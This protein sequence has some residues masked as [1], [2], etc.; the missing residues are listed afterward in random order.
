MFL[1]IPDFFLHFLNLDALELLLPGQI[2]ELHGLP[3]HPSNFPPQE[4]SLLL[5]L[6]PI[7]LERKDMPGLILILRGQHPCGMLQLAQGVVMLVCEGLDLVAQGGDLPP[8]LLQLLLLGV[9][10]VP[11]LQ[12]QPVVGRQFVL[13]HASQPVVH[14]LRDQPCHHLADLRQC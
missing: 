9:D 14:V 1:I 7:I 2:I 13:R 4:L 10:Q 3:L 6:L 8:V 12:Q 11:D 5:Q